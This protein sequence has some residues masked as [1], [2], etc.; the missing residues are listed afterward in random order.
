MDEELESSGEE[1]KE[2]E[3][4]RRRDM[5]DD[6]IRGPFTVR[7]ASADPHKRRKVHNTTCGLVNKM[8]TTHGNDN[9]V[10]TP[11]DCATFNC[12]LCHKAKVNQ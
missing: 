2:E 6:L 9:L 3:D 5:F 8:L 12:G 11:V 7:A 10:F 4:E 1:E